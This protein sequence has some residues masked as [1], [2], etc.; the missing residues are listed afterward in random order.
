MK[1]FAEAERRDR[2]AELDWIC[3]AAACSVAL[4]AEQ[5][6]LP[7]FVNVEPDTFATPCP[8]DLL[9]IYD[10]A[11]TGL[12]LVIEITERMITRPAALLQALNEVRRGRGRIALDDIGSDPSSLNM[13]SLVRPDVI[14]LDRSIVQGDTASWPIAYV[15]NAVLREAE[16]TGSAVLAEGIETAEHLQAAISMGATL[17]QGFYLGRP[18]PLPAIIEASTQTVPRVA[19]DPRPPRHHSRSCRTGPKPSRSAKRP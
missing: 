18:G 12:D 15:I 16:R 4:A 13:L 10:A 2:V 6:A 1:L 5:L 14:K 3:V 17:G 8:P 7:V 19:R 9:T 11:T